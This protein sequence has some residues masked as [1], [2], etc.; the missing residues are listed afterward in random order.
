MKKIGYL[1]LFLSM[2]LMFS[3]TTKKGGVDNP[4]DFNT[5]NVNVFEGSSYETAVVIDKD[6]ES[7]GVRAEYEWINQHYPASQVLGQSL[8][9]YKDKPYDIIDIVNGKGEKLSLYFDIS[10][11]FGKF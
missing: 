11:F 7:E 4:K 8:N 2:T 10:K 6:S 5:R 1:F 9:Y 3:C